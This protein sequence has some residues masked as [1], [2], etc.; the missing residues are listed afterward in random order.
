MARE[1]AW[2]QHAR[3]FDS[4]FDNINGRQLAKIRAWS[5]AKLTET[6]SVLFYMFSGPDFPLRQC[7]FP[8]TVDLRN[9]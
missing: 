2:Q 1:H 8:E 9:K 7:V 6:H 4:I 3:Y 5:S